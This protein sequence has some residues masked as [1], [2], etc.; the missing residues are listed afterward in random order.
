MRIKFRT[1]L[2]NDYTDL[3]LQEQ[4]EMKWSVLFIYFTKR[5][6]LSFTLLIPYFIY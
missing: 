4:V 5:K 2:Q 6:A 3:D 1:T